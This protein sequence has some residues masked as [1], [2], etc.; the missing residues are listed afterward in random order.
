M[1]FLRRSDVRIFAACTCAV[2]LA[3][4]AIQT[5]S[6]RR[7]VSAGV[8]VRDFD[9]M[10]KS[11]PDL[12]RAMEAGSVTS[13]QLTAIYL[14]RIQAYDKAGP[15]LN[16]MLAVNPRV[17]D[18]ADAL[19]RDRAAG[20]LRGPLHGIPIVIKD[21]FE[22]ADMP[23]TAGSLALVG[24]ET[25]RDAFQVKKLRDAGAVIVGKTNLHELASGIT[26]ISSLG[27]QTLNPYDLDRTPGGSSGGTGAAVAANFAVAGM[28]SDTCG[29]IRIPAANNNLF[30]LRGT[31]GLSSRAG[32]VPLSHTQDIGGP[33]ARTVTDLAIML[34]ATVGVDPADSTTARSSGHVPRSYRD[35]LT[36]NGLTGV[37]IGVLKQLF[38]TAPEDDEVGRIVRNA[39]DAIKKAGADTMDVNIPGLDEQM[40]GSSVINAEFKFD[41]ADYLAGHRA[42][43]V[44]SLTEIL[45]SGRYHASLDANFKTRNRPEQR[46]TDEYRRALVKRA[47]VRQL[48]LAAMEE[49]RLDA[50]AYPTLRRPPAIIGEPQRGTNCQLSPSTGLPVVAMPAGFADGVPVGVELL[51]GDWSEPALLKMAYAYEQATR[52]RRPPF[53]APA[54]INGV[55]PAPVTFQA[56]VGGATARFTYDRTSTHLAYVV[57]AQADTLA[58]TLHRGAD[59]EKGPVVARLADGTATTAS[60][61]IRLGAM[62]REALEGGR[63]YL[64]VAVKHQP[65]GSRAQVRV[66]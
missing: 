34:D 30:G 16:A 50:L 26:T 9:I 65:A 36:A 24:F 5:Q 13:H 60:G 3:A 11:I 14:A 17:L 29:S 39:I 35:A 47:T 57:T 19:D 28:G 43:P 41:L 25:E 52:P 12:Q 6:T 59:G 44:H 4:P 51:G 46:D 20:R 8:V 55:A 32:I 48:V 2:L 40:Q 7:P 45:D 33:L 37:R 18:A 10:E 49:Q 58:V 54:L 64:E 27:G 22:T 63:L 62:D 56:L 21:N 38:G 15:R 1:I 66:R 61:D 23:T 42:P 53:S 31:S